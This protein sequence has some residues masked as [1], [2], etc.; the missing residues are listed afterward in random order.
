LI[1]FC[2]A[3]KGKYFPVHAMNA[4]RW[5]IGRLYFHSFLTL[6][7]GGRP[8][9]FTP[10]KKPQFPWNRRLGGPQNLS[11]RCGEENFIFYYWIRSPNRPASG[12]FAVPTALLRLPIL[13]F[14]DHLTELTRRQ[15]LPEVRNIKDELCDVGDVRK[16]DA[17]L[18][19][20]RYDAV[21]I[22]LQMSPFRIILLPPS[23]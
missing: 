16:T 12:L 13:H 14:R 5:N 3:G 6:A 9:C 15:C 4:Y 7:L 11:G 21:W 20:L 18:N 1:I 19:I 8:V 10:C 17:D 22:C 23:V 2:I